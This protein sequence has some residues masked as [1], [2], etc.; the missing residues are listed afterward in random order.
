MTFGLGLGMLVSAGVFDERFSEWRDSQRF[1]QVGK[2][3]NIGGRSLNL[4]CSGSGAQSDYGTRV[5]A[6][7]AM[8]GRWSSVAFP[9]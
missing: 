7:L 2:L 6:C 9:N 3:V 1:P 5:E 4:Y 8:A